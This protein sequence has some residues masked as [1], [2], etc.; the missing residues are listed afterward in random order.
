MASVEKRTRNGR[1]RWVA[2]YRDPAGNSRANTFDRK[3]DAE[4]F[5]TGTESSKLAG[6]YVDAR[7]GALT[8]AQFYGSG[9]SDRCGRRVPRRR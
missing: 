5:L 2:R 9:P 6:T 3:V 1:L 8:V 7:A 4:K